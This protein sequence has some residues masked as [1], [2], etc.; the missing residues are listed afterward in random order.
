MKGSSNW[1]RMAAWALALL[2]CIGLLPLGAATTRAEGE[3]Y[4]VVF[5]CNGY[6]SCSGLEYI[7]GTPLTLPAAAAVNTAYA[8]CLSF[9]GWQLD[10][11]S[12][13]SIPADYTVG[14]AGVVTVV[15][16]WT[17]TQDVYSTSYDG[18]WTNQDVT[19]TARNGFT[20][21]PTSY[22]TE[23]A[24][25]FAFTQ[26]GASA[27][28]TVAGR[29]ASIPVMIDK[30]AP[31]IEEPT[32]SPVYS[33]DWSP[34]VV[35][36]SFQVSDALS[37]VASVKVDNVTITPDLDGFYRFETRNGNHS[38]TLLATDTAGNDARQTLNINVDTVNPELSLSANESWTNAESVDV[39]AT[40]SQVPY[41]GAEGTWSRGVQSGAFDYQDTGHGTS[42]AVISVTEEGSI[43]I[44]VTARTYAGRDYSASKTI[45]IDR[46]LPTISTEIS[47]APN[48]AGWYKTAP[49][50]TLT[51]AD[52]APAEGVATSGVA[53]YA[54]K[55]DGGAWDTLSDLA[56]S[57]FL[58]GTHTYAFRVTDVAGNHADT[59][60][61]TIKLD[62]VT[63]SIAVTPTETTWTNQPVDLHVSMDAMDSGNN[64]SGVYT[65]RNRAGEPVTVMFTLDEDGKATITIS[66]ECNTDVTFVVTSVAGIDSDAVIAKVQI[67]T[68]AP[69]IDTVTIG[70]DVFSMIDSVITFNYITADTYIAVDAH[71]DWGELDYGELYVANQR[72]D[73]AALRTDAAFDENG[74]ATLVLDANI[75]P[76]V[77]GILTFTAY[78]KAQ[79]SSESAKSEEAVTIE[80]SNASL[81]LTLAYARWRGEAGEPGEAYDGN[82]EIVSTDYL[83]VQYNGSAYAGIQKYY[84]ALSPEG[85]FTELTTMAFPQETDDPYFY[86][87]A[88]AATVEGSA[89][90]TVPPTVPSFTVLFRILPE[91][92]T[93]YFKA[94]SNAGHETAVQSITVPADGLAPVVALE[95]SAE[96][97]ANGDTGFAYYDA[98]RT[99]TI[100][101][102]EHNFV[103]ET[104]TLTFTGE[105]QINPGAI[106]ATELTWEEL[107]AKNADDTLKTYRASYTFAEGKYTDIAVSV[108]DIATNNTTIA[109]PDFIVDT[110]APVLSIAPTSP[111]NNPA[112]LGTIDYYHKLRTCTVTVVDAN[113]DPDKAAAFFATSGAT[114][115]TTANGMWTSMAASFLD[116][117]TASVPQSWA[118]TALNTYVCTIPFDEGRYTDGFTLQVSDYAQ[119]KSEQIAEKPFI[120]DMTAPVIEVSSIVSDHLANFEGTDTYFHAVPSLDVTVTITDNVSGVGSVSILSPD[121]QN[122]VP[123]TSVETGASLSESAPSAKEEIVI[124]VPENALGKI[125]ANAKDW[126]GL[127]GEQVETAQFAVD[128]TS[129]KCT[130]TFSEA[131]GANGGKDYY[132]IAEGEIVVSV[133]IEEVFFDQTKIDQSISK[134]GGSSGKSFRFSVDSTTHR[135]QVTLTDD[136][137]YKV[138]LTYTDFAGHSMEDYASNVKVLDTVAPTIV[139]DG[140]Q[141]R[142]AYADACTPIVTCYDRNMNDD[143]LKILFA[144]KNRGSLTPNGSYADYEGSD[145]AHYGAVT[146]LI[147]T[148]AAFANTRENDDVYTLQVSCTDYA[149]NTTDSTNASAATER[150]FS[151]N[152]NG[153]VFYYEKE[154]EA[155]NGTYINQE[156]TLLL[157]EI[158]VTEIETTKILIT[159]S[160]QSN[161]LTDGN[162]FTVQDLSEADG[163][164]EYVYSIQDA[165][166]AKE[167]SYQ[168]V[169]RSEDVTE[170]IYESTD[171]GR[172]AEVDAAGNVV[173]EDAGADMAFTVDKTAPQLLFIDLGEQRADNRSQGD[174]RFVQFR[175]K[176][177]CK[178][179]QVTLIV[180]GETR[181]FTADSPEVTD[182][183]AR[184]WELSFTLG[185]DTDWQNVSVAVADTA[186]NE[187]APK[188]YQALV[189]SNLL[190]QY[191][192]NKPLFYGTIGGA[193]LLLAAVILLI[194]LRK[195]SKKA[196]A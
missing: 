40:L 165:N 181:I 196:K 45:Q 23:G 140:V 18:T 77:T 115:G 84:W 13:T 134:N 162:G 78:D 9:A 55:I 86:S 94:E 152:R 60:A 186:G 191:F 127:S 52:P 101:V 168:V 51:V 35:T 108:T 105:N 22:G 20:V 38:Y 146:G 54:V 164:K 87:V 116:G 178:L 26:D 76:D 138:F 36:V 122:T 70:D 15:A 7:A 192:Y 163:W 90:K 11:A 42:R 92:T 174:S 59:E 4:P 121:A 71:D 183:S 144:G 74:K 48:D 10:G 145:D 27:P 176:D 102:A 50:I 155:I 79:N 142:T 169:A 180:N 137:D 81:D 75:D 110:T 114:A 72:G 29:D 129:P 175:V 136:A 143:A 177:D 17:L 112:P 119:N 2:L 49:T 37:G 130:V 161:E 39:T 30:T 32:Y 12:V 1:A 171:E 5:Q 28:A 149:G 93:F 73:A 100:T 151:L 19:I 16:T 14:E 21:S 135:A 184:E 150:I 91:V 147:F 47:D 33:G 83:E 123:N 148:F 8:D 128:N 109:I 88:L 69:I 99:L 173:A 31:T 195:K 156:Q 133:V 166:F 111:D 120:V 182:Q 66:E 63:P 190:V 98:D 189:T 34:D 185:E 25:M 58:N 132:G 179:D 82:T 118:K 124:T 43:A 61:V 68:T 57:G 3:S 41:S 53:S 106:N 62:T 64:A 187:S 67:D 6:G 44:A 56:F 160:L 89:D 172:G 103:P 113:F 157:H 154:S 141:N 24:G 96:N 159:G 170:L 158:N 125:V 139:I 95:W 80:T 117:T 85:P 46:T 126:S 193:V 167:D 97:A 104:S 194:A 107:S 65:Y 131:Y 188:A 153:S